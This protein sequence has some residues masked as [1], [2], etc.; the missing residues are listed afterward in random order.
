MEGG[1]LLPGSMTKK[2][3]IGGNVLATVTQRLAIF[4]GDPAARTL[5]ELLPR[6]ASR[7]YVTMLNEW[8]HHGGIRE[9]HSEFLVGE[10]SGI[11]RERMDERL[12]LF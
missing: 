6:E 12:W 3:C 4:S 5:L 9:P 7:P 10:R 2:C 11:K 1:D 8:L